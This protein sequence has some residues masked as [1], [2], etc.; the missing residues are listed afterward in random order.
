MCINK[1]N[2]QRIKDYNKN[3]KV[4]KCVYIDIEDMM[5]DSE[6]Y[7]IS[8]TC[9]Y[10]KKK[11]YVIISDW[12]QCHIPKNTGR[13]ESTPAEFLLSYSILTLFQTTTDNC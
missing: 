2:S 8:C 3:L 12:S 13:H 7:L 9:H 11:T 1:W 10:R 5:Y 6:K 4:E